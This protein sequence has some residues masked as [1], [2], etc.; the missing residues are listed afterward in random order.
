MSKNARTATRRPSGRR[1]KTAVAEPPSPQP[2]PSAP[3]R[4]LRL[5]ALQWTA[6][7]ILLG[8]A[9]VRTYALS[10]KVLHHDEGVNG[11]FM[12]SLF[13][14]GY[15]HYDPSNYHGPTLYYFGWITTTV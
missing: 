4:F 15:Y 14:T 1:I 6:A 13:R 7:A 3:R 12:A 9:I 8:A 10:M 5:D 2:Q 11:L